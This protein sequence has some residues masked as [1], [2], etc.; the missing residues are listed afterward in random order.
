MIHKTRG[1]VLH[2]L[3]YSDTSL[4]VKIY[5]ELLGLQT[6][7][8]KGA[9][10]KKS[11]VRNSYFQP[12]TLLNLVV[13][14]RKKNELQHLREAEIS[15]PFHSISS[16][17][18][19]STIVLFLSEVLMKALNE[20]EA[21]EEM[22]TFFSSSLKFLDVQ[23]RGIEY[24]HLFFLARLSLYLGF[25]PRGNPSREG[26]Y[27]DLREGSFSANQPLHPDY[28]SRELGV[29]LFMLSTS[30]ATEIVS[31]NINR[32][33]RTELLDGILLFFRLHLSG[34]GSIKSAGILKEVFD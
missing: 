16:D 1:I 29:K 12:M 31:F 8:V 15:E 13:Y 10:S 30:K 14:H 5:T 17:L 19:K 25:Y 21:N 7:L 34:L 33:M 3:K 20:G 6:Y 11:A 23:E 18:R 2:Q 24:F 9:Q 32:D 4:I 27:F 28:L 26:E 22:F